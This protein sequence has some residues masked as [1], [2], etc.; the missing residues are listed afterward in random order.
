MP[1]EDAPTPSSPVCVLFFF[2]LVMFDSLL[3][4]PKCQIAKT[5]L[6]NP[7]VLSVASYLIPGAACHKDSRSSMKYRLQFQAVTY[8]I[9]Q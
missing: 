6:Q 2:E 9:R 3:K 7:E 5:D 4:W 8:P 1:P